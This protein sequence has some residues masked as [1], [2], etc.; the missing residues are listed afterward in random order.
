MH[1]LLSKM[2]V[3]KNSPLT[4]F[5]RKLRKRQVELDS[6]N[7][8][9]NSSSSYIPTPYCTGEPSVLC[10]PISSSNKKLFWN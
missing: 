10:S 9:S 5:E 3:T 4:G 8:N 1:D 7:P 6:S 2:T